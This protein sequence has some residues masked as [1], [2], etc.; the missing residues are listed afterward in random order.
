MSMTTPL[1]SRNLD[2]LRAIAV[3]AVFVDHTLGRTLMPDTRALAQMGRAGVLLFFVHTSLVLMGSIERQQDGALAFYIRRAFRIYPLAIA[4]VVGVAGF[5]LASLPAVTTPRLLANL[6]L[7][8]NLFGA[9]DVIGPL[10]SLPLEVQMYAVLPL[11]F[12]VARK[13]V[14]ATLLLFVLAV[15]VGVLVRVE[16]HLWRLS[17][18]LYGPCF[19]SGILAYA[20]LRRAPRAVIPPSLWPL[21]VLCVIA[22]AV[23]LE[24]TA[25]QPVRGWFICLAIG[26]LIPF[27]RDMEP[28]R[29]TRYAAKV[30]TYSYGIYLLHVPALIVVFVHGADWPSAVQWPA[31]LALVTTLAL[32]GYHCI[33]KPGITLG[34]RVSARVASRHRKGAPPVRLPDGWH[35]PTARKS[36]ERTRR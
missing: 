13:G 5:G 21:V 26:L 19:V 35:L 12:V 32:L 34:K 20:L 17:V 24:A 10:W 31:Y 6:T 25:G 29:L 1:P 18:G 8:Q 27:V 7:T 2:V 15:V 28:S 14:R 22:G 16:P 11:C 4:T 36:G 9:K 30:A 3:L 33:E 23:L